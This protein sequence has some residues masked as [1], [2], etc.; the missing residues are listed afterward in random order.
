MALRLIIYIC[1]ER[2]LLGNTK[3]IDIS[4]RFHIR[5]MCVQEVSNP[6]YLSCTPFYQPT[7]P[8]PLY[9]CYFSAYVI[10]YTYH[11]FCG[12]RLP[13]SD[14]LCQGG[15]IAKQ[16]VPNCSSLPLF[17]FCQPLHISTLH[18]VHYLN[19]SWFSSLPFNL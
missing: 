7:D 5:F 14:I 18:Q 3:E 8:S 19:R 17:T 6:K 4:K 11:Q 1:W 16:K 9:I 12:L 2:D 10:K 15:N 13:W